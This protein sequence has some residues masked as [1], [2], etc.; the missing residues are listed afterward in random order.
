VVALIQ[1]DRT[2]QIKG[3]DTLVRTGTFPTHAERAAAV[4]RLVQSVMAQTNHATIA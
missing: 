4:E 2:V 3:S 1:S